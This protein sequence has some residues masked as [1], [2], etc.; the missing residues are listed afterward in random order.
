MKI[1]LLSILRKTYQ[2][3]VVC[4]PSVIVEFV[5]SLMVC[6]EDSFSQ[7]CAVLVTVVSTR[8]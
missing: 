1:K 3:R 8:G 7:S 2:R 6:G 4:L 5:L